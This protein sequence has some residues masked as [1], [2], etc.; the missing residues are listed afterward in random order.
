LEA[1]LDLT[2]GDD[3]R[4]AIGAACDDYFA[5]E[6]LDVGVEHDSGGV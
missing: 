2:P 4:E 5:Q 3:N 6:M 1:R